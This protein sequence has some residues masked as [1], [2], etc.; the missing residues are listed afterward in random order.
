[1]KANRTHGVRELRGTASTIAPH[2]WRMVD[3]GDLRD[4]FVCDGCGMRV[5]VKSGYR[6][7]RDISKMVNGKPV[8]IG[9]RLPSCTVARGVK[10]GRLKEDAAH[11]SNAEWRDV[12]AT[13]CD[14]CGERWARDQL[15]LEGA[16][17]TQDQEVE[18]LR[19]HAAVRVRLLDA[20]DALDAVEARER[21][22]R[23]ERLTCLAQG[24]GGEQTDARD[25]ARRVPMAGGAM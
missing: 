1:M 15:G 24:V 3:Q 8:P 16:R 6:P 13:V 17:L 25:G 5:E 21:Q 22:I 14:H 2:K 7:A 12:W 4:T 18:L 11:L 19:I 20:D 23:R 9:T 10:L